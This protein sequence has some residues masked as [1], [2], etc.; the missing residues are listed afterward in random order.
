MSSVQHKTQ[1]LF[2]IIMN[3]DLSL[4]LAKITSLASVTNPHSLNEP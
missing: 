1:I 2:K 4:S 3:V